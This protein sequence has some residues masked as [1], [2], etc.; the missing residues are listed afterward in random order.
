VKDRNLWIWG[1]HSVEACLDSFPE[2]VLEL[3]VEEEALRASPELQK[4]VKAAKEAGVR[5]DSVRSLP[6]D[7]ADKRTQGCLAL[8]K[9][10]PTLGPSDLARVF[11][12]PAPKRLRQWAV[13]DRIEDPR[14]FGAILRSAAAFGLS[15]VIFGDKQQAPL[16]AVVAQASAGQ[17]FRVPLYEVSNPNMLFRVFDEQVHL[18]AAVAVLDMEGVSLVRAVKDFREGDFSDL[19]W[20]L[21]SEGRGVRP[22][23]IEKASHRVS[24][25]MEKSVESLNVSVASSLAFYAMY[26]SLES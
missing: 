11:E 17:C 10:A 1:W 6:K 26:Q 4:I 16:T 22:G 12:E 3:K 8:L 7:Y 9:R 14:N 23:L 21:G 19:V 13:L 25:P 15:G 5:V 24:I 20:I 18:R 2:L